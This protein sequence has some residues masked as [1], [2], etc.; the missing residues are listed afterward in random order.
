[1]K[2]QDKEINAGVYALICLWSGF[3]Y[4]GA[5]LWL[6][7]RFRQ[8]LDLLRL[9]RHPCEQLQKEWNEFGADCFAMFPL[10]LVEDKAKLCARERAWT[11]K[12]LVEGKVYNQRNAVTER[13]RKEFRKCRAQWPDKPVGHSAKEYC[14]VSPEGEPVK[15]KGLRGICEA[16]RL[17]PSHLSKVARGLYV[18]HRGWTLGKTG[19]ALEK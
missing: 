5:S 11:K 2:T 1:V 6:L 13:H 4:V 7:K 9:N 17:N 18:Q 8:H 19:E 16:Y 14:F 12:C 10:E 3:A 15:V